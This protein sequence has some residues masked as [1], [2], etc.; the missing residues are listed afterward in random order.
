MKA[1]KTTSSLVLVLYLVMF[2][3]PEAYAQ[4]P[5][6]L[7]DGVATMY[8]DAS[9]QWRA[10]ILAAA[11]KLFWL[12]ALIDLSWNGMELALKR[13]GL[14]DAFSALVRWVMTISFFLALLQY[15]NVWGAAI[16]N[17]FRQLGANA[18]TQ[19]PGVMSGLDPSDIF[20]LGLRVSTDLVRSV[21]FADIGDS[22]VRSSS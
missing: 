14:Q 5:N 9:E 3:A 2:L 15:S 21:S 13:A 20:D 18:G 22:I 16:I 12:L 6:N 7:I 10:P 11:T 19:I 1:M 17:S 4:T 8:R